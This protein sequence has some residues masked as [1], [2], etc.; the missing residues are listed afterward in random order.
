MAPSNTNT[1]HDHDTPYLNAL[2]DA[3]PDDAIPLDL[4]T[5]STSHSVPKFV[6]AALRLA[7][8]GSSRP[9]DDA[10]LRDAWPQIQ[11]SLQHALHALGS[12]P[13]HAKRKRS[14]SPS[15]A[16]APPTNKKPKHEEEED[17]EEDPPHLTLHALSATA[18]V[19]HK[20][21]ITLHARSLRLAHATTGALVA[22]CARAALTRAFLLP[23]RARATGAPQWT[24]LLL[25]GDTPTPA[26]SAASRKNNG[27]GA[28]KGKEKVSARF[29]LACSVSEAGK[30]PHLTS[31]RSTSTSASSS[32]SLLPTPSTPHQA[33][34][35]LLSSLSTSTPT[36]GTGTY[37]APKLVQ[38]ERGARLAG[39][40]AFRGARETSLWFLEGA[41][42]LVDTRPAEF[43]ALADLARGDA[44]VRVLSATGRTC[45][46]ILTRCPPP[47]TTEGSEEDDEGEETEF[48]MIDG[49][50]R[51]GI[52][53]WVRKHKS[54]FGIA[55]AQRAGAG[56]GTEG[57][58]VARGDSDSDSDFE[59]E[60][61]GSDDGSPSSGGSSSG[62]GE[63]E[64]GEE[65][66]NESGADEGAEGS[67]EAESDDEGDDE[68]IVELDP[69]RHPLLRAAAAGAIPKMSR[70]AVDAAVGLVVDDLVGRGSS[71][72]GLQAPPSTHDEHGHRHDDDGESEEDELED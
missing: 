12:P 9:D 62:P 30:V 38:I 40:T 29:E 11:A 54:A 24:A 23:T 21:D 44:G 27:A 15:P 33:L 63:H 67:A 7:S 37:P 19:R 59:Q 61:G 47:H 60:S 65:S 66:G 2:L 8:G 42:I 16:Q 68:E 64:G 41:G 39:I 53:E 26:P 10:R 43:W 5:A 14:P 3:V 31:H 46:V 55:I 49:K 48:Q 25:A 50:E 28:A 70:A 71:A 36:T 1:T 20:V 56:T 69:K 57:G 17:G 6:D 34:L 72:P 4:K 13:A 52:M 18:P 45:T 35:S 22:R 32:S 51:E 58:V